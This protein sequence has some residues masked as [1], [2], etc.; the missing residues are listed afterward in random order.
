[1]MSGSAGIPNHA[2]NQIDNGTGSRRSKR[3]PELK[4]CSLIERVNALTLK[5]FTNQY[6]PIDAVNSLQTSTSLNLSLQTW[7]S[8]PPTLRTACLNLIELT[9]STHYQSSEMGWSRAKKLKEMRH[10]AMKYSLLLPS[11]LASPSHTEEG[12]QGFL[13]FMV[14]EEDG[15][16]VIYCYELH[17]QPE[18]QGQGLGKRMMEVMEIMGARVGVEKAMLTVFRS[19]EKA[20]RAYQKWGYGVD[21]FSPEGRRLRDGTVKESSYVILSKKKEA[22]A[23]EED[24]TKQPGPRDE[25]HQDAPRRETR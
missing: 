17:L 16:D 1:M 5:D 25:S 7:T 15:Y 14:T 19:N 12:V 6:L 2:T 4:K 8:M 3:V 11:A 10:P 13:S 18:R 22:F 20:V 23:Q 9:N 24:V 21:E